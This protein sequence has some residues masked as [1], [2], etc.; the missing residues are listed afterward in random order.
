[1]ENLESKLQA[2]RAAFAG[3]NTV[4]ELLDHPVLRGRARWRT[5]PTEAGGIEALLPPLDFGGE[6]RMD[7]VPALGQHTRRVLADPGREEAIIGKLEKC[8]ATQ[9]R[10]MAKSVWS[11]TR[12]GGGDQMTPPQAAHMDLARHVEDW[13]P[14]D[15]DHADVI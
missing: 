10:A 3:V 2:A 6:V 7:P 15:T 11:T 9:R 12:H 4:P 5:V 8:A 14:P 13:R 1:T